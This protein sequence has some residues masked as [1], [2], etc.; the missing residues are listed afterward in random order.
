MYDKGAFLAH[1]KKSSK[2]I[3][4]FGFKTPLGVFRPEESISDLRIY[5]RPRQIAQT[6]H[7]RISEIFEKSTFQHVG[8]S[9]ICF[10]QEKIL[11]IYVFERK[12]S[13]PKRW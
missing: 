7:F 9:K 6:G 12:N 5:P 2:M 1:P 8:G 13:S 10:T 11:K 4:K 3:E